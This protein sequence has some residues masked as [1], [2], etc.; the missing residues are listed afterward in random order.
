MPHL[1]GELLRIRT[2][3]SAQIMQTHNLDTSEVRRLRVA[4]GRDDGRTGS[5]STIN[6]S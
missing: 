2:T 4:S 5:L 6:G 3:T 1:R